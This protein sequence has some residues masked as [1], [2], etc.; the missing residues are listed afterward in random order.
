MKE[1]EAAAGTDQPA[2]DDDEPNEDADEAEEVPTGPQ[3]EPFSQK[4]HSIIKARQLVN[5][6]RHHD[7]SK[8]RHYCTRRLH[9]IY[10]AVKYK[11]ANAKGRYKA[12]VWP[13]AAQLDDVRWLEMLLMTAERAWSYAMQLKGEMA[14]A[15]EFN[16]A[17]RKK[18]LRRFNRAVHWAEKLFEEAKVHADQR[19]C[20][21][22]DAYY[23]YMYGTFILE[24]T[25]HNEALDK[26][27]RA[28]RLYE[29]LSIASEQEERD[30][31]KERSEALAPM[32]RECRYHLGMGY[33]GADMEKAD[34]ED[35]PIGET[36]DLKYRGSFLAVPSDEVKARLQQCLSICSDFEVPDHGDRIHVIKK[37]DE[38]FTTYSANMKEIHNDLLTAGG[39]GQTS[40]WRRLEAFAREKC[41]CMNLERNLLLLRNQMDKLDKKEEVNDSVAGR[42][43]FKVEKGIK[44][45]DLIKEEIETIQE[46]PDTSEQIS[47]MLTAYA[48]VIRNCRCLFMALCFLS[49]GK[50]QESAAVF[51]LLHA[52]LGDGGLGDALE[53]PLG[54]LHSLFEYVQQCTLPMCGKW[55]CKALAELCRHEILK[56]RKEKEEPAPAPTPVDE[57]GEPAAAGAA[58]SQAKDKEGEKP[59]AKAKAKEKGADSKDKKAAGGAAAKKGARKPKPVIPSLA[60]VEFP[61]RV[62]DI[63]C[64][65]LL[66]DLAF[67]CITAP[68]LEGEDDSKQTGGEGPQK[69]GSKGI[70]G[71]VAGGI[72]SRIGGLWGG[73]K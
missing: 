50:L 21:E 44:Y 69:D 30:I 51:D 13:A 32:I 45:C 35:A 72:G 66:F 23:H 57:E 26:L 54:R 67:P 3:H 7:Y 16:N 43:V 68:N 53:E 10:A 14:V 36:S 56:K 52:R 33:T 60:L 12:P 22:A 28:F 70:I 11:H 2:E 49:V 39:E 17:T 27:T 47:D 18:S 42:K 15:V 19:T 31:F 48:M 46:L 65:P 37:Y 29:Q 20:L 6:L 5:G 58:E 40:A 4:M 73:R 59:K 62:C 55:R 63:A 9:T 64:K 71:R 1:D 24:K 25:N 41:V 34:A 61:P 38:L 8:Y